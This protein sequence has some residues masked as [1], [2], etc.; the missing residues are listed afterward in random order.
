MTEINLIKI[1]QALIS[2][3]VTLETLP[4]K[5]THA[6][7]TTTTTTT[8]T[9]TNSNNNYYYHNGNKNNDSKPNNNNSSKNDS[10]KSF[11]NDNSDESYDCSLL[12]QAF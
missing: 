10:T 2:V 8:T 1:R 12:A 6:T 5:R 11:S 7:S 4:T 9:T 3:R